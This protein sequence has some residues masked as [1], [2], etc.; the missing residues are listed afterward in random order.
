MAVPFLPLV[1]S[2]ILKPP[3]FI[4]KQMV[5]LGFAFPYNGQV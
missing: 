4:D 1:T 5:E 3:D 2:S